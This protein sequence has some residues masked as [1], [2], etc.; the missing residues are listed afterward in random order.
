MRDQQSEIRE[1]RALIRRGLA[2]MKENGAAIRCAVEEGPGL[3]VVCD[4]IEAAEKI[5]K[6]TRNERH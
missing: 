2:A 5:L 3:C 6:R 4:W 1:L